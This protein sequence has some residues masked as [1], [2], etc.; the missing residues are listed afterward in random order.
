MDIKYEVQFYRSSSIKS[1]KTA[2]KIQSMFTDSKNPQWKDHFRDEL[3]LQSAQKI[4]TDFEKYASK[5]GLPVVYRIV[6]RTTT[7]TDTVVE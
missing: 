6:F 4:K 7:V 1:Q 5:K 2:Y 3:D